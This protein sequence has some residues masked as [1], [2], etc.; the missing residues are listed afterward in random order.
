[1]EDFAVI[2]KSPKRLESETKVLGRAHYADDFKFHREA[3][4]LPLYP[5][6]PRAL[7]RSI[8]TGDAELMPGVLCVATAKDVP[9]SNSLFGRFPV[10]AE[11]EVRYTGDVVAVVA[12]ETEELAAKALE[13]I[14]VDYEELPGIFSLE[15][16]Q[17]AEIPPVHADRPDNSMENTFYPQYAGDVDVGLDKADIVLEAEY[18]TSFAVNGYIEPDCVVATEDPIT[19]GVAIYGCI[20]NVYSI[21]GSVCAALNLP[22][23]Q[24]RVVQTAIGGSFGGKNETAMVIA[25]RA[26]ILS[27]MTGRPVRIRMDRRD[28][29]RAGVKRHPYRFRFTAGCTKDG[30]IQ[31]WR[32]TVDTIGGP[33]NNQAMFANWRLAVHSAGPYRTPNVRTQVQAYYSN[34]PYSGAYRG[35][36]APQNCFAVESYMDELAQA[37]GIDPAEFRRINFVR[38]GDTL[39]CGQDVGPGAMVLP[40][41]A[42]LDDV[43]LRGR[44]AE[45]KEKFEAFNDRKGRYRRGLGLA[46]SYRGCGLGGEGFDVAGARIILEK[47]GSILVHSD[48]V[49]MGQGMRTSHAQV[50]AETLGVGLTR[51]RMA[52][53][54]TSSVPDAGPTV[55]SR[56][57]SAGGMAIL[58]AAEDLKRKLLK[59]MDGHWNLPPGTAELKDELFRGRDDEQTMGFDEAVSLLTNSKGLGFA[60]QGW[61]NPGT[62]HIDP[63]TGVGNCY[64]AYLSAI[65]LTEL[66]VDTFTGALRVPRVTLAYELG[67]AIN[68]D[69]VRG[70][71]IGG[72][73]QGLG[74]ALCEDLKTS[75][76]L[77]TSTSFE[78]YAMPLASDVP[79]FDLRIWEEDTSTGPYGAKGI[80][81]VGVELAAP[82]VGNALFHATGIRLRSVPMTKDIIAVR[83]L[84]LEEEGFN[85]LL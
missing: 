45:K 25:S 85:E 56:G 30:A 49:E 43:L 68:P 18:N 5:P 61:F 40:L 2:T 75:R 12:A 26:A 44:Y 32:N 3:A 36:S 50:A 58:K 60:G 4:A 29:F 62:V 82:G 78:S 67:R 8:D 20:Q 16:A 7:I 22:A 6:H 59:G 70:Q 48:M 80:G 28:V 63:E 77:V 24:V 23:N 83:M 13:K 27:R 11:G 47:D 53:T 19:G 84:E 73:V 15:D 52:E 21:R 76:G 41:E 74:Y 55:A 10:L 81:E 54:D 17:S 64:P 33:Y 34:T 42:M 69:I 57:L 1:M 14:R 31:A 37:A 38:P 65:S 79:E 66:E 39:T 71:L 9:G 72:Y 35:F 51:I 46:A